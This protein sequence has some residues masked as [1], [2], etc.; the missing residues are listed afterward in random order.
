MYTR[1]GWALSGFVVLLAAGCTEPGGLQPVSG[2][3]TFEGKPLDQ[4][5]IQFLPFGAGPTESGAGIKDGKYSIPAANG[6]SPGRYKVTVFSYDETGPK[7][8]REEIPGDPGGM[9]FKERIPARYNTETTL[10]AEVVAGQK[11]E[12][13]F[14]LDA[15]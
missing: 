1:V 12:F 3:V 7:V 6:L 14:Q 11:N 15:P 2:T 5:A 9:Q 13:N 10:T 4:G 8:P